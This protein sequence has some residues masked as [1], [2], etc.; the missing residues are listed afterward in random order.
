M[1]Y[2]LHNGRWTR[3]KATKPLHLHHIIPRGWSS[4]YSN[5]GEKFKVNGPD[6][7]II[8]CAH[9]HWVIHPDM[10][11]CFRSDRE[12]NKDAFQLMFEARE[13]RCLRGDPYWETK[14]DHWMLWELV[15]LANQKFG[16][17]YPI[18][19]NETVEQAR[20]A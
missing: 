13:R 10:P 19:G 16:E 12:G 11:P 4:H 20:R 7:G 9:H 3:C 1:F 14:Y 18:C 5:L 2:E 6:N 15:H 8:L 17:P